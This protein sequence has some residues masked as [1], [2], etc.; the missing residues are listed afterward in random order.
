M[1]GL[2][3]YSRVNKPNQTWSGRKLF[4]WLETNN[5]QSSYLGD[6]GE[7]Q[8]TAW[9]QWVDGVYDGGWV[10]GVYNGGWVYEAYNAGI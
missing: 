8:N 6:G 1:H 7:L 5:P 3:K 2:S 10:D 9:F 4:G